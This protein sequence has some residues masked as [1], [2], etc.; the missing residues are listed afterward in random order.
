MITYKDI[1]MSVN[2]LLTRHFD[3]EINSNDVQEGF[4]RPSFFVSLDNPTRSS[5]MSQIERSLTIRIYYFPSDR[6]NYSVE[7]MDIQ[8]RLENLFD[9]KLSVKDRK[10][11]IVDVV[12]NVTDGVLNLSFDI[13]FS[14]AR[15][16]VYDEQP[17]EMMQTLQDTWKG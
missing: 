14:D 3:I 6:Y 13:E 4:I 11:N 15:E 16:V 12:S 1:K 7:L 10:F 8:E 2:S 5:L 17:S 9:L